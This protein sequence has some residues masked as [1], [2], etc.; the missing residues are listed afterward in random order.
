MSILPSRHFDV[1]MTSY[2]K[3]LVDFGF[4]IQKYPSTPNLSKIKPISW[5]IC[6]FLHF[7]VLQHVYNKRLPWQHPRL[8]RIVIMCKMSPISVRLNLKNFILISCAVLELSR[9]VSQRGRNPPP[10]PPGEIGLKCLNYNRRPN[11]S[12]STSKYDKCKTDID[13]QKNLDTVKV[14]E[15]EH[16]DDNN[17]DN[18][19]DNFDF[20]DILNKEFLLSDE[21][22]DIVLTDVTTGQTNKTAPLVTLTDSHFKIILSPTG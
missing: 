9:K 10:P 8:M 19:V 22:D 2:K 14:N 16:I 13:I 21:M 20:E 4:R 11:N 17:T 12:K 1:K 7:S 15:A 3:F 18:L 6:N 5:Q